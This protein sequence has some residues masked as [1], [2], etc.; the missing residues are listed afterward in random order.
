MI[1]ENLNEIRKGIP[2]GV[3]LACVSKFHPV[4]AIEEAYAAGERVFAES[5][6]Q[7]FVAK[8]EVL[9]TDIEWHFIGNLQTNKVKMV[10]PHATLIHSM[11]ND[12]LFDEVE[13]C[14]AKI[15]KVQDV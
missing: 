15:D 7:E 10:V 2:E 12:R 5:R 3:E 14:A 6:P 11:A 8:V 13:K 9:P 4:E 1:K